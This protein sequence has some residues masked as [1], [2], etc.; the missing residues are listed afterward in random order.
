MISLRHYDEISQNAEDESLS[1]EYS[2]LGSMASGIGYEFVHDGKFRGAS[3]NYYTIKNRRGWNQY[4]GT[5]ANMNRTITAS[6]IAVGA[7][8]G[9]GVFAGATIID[10]YN[11]K[12]IN[13][14]QA[15]IEGGSV[16]FSTIAPA[17]MSIPWNIGYEGI[18]RQLYGRN[19]LGSRDFIRP[20][21]R[22]ALNIEG[23]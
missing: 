2:I 5:K 9:L 12:R 17:W 10:Q 20:R 21:I 7:N 15:F 1:V 4:T 18:G 6:K 23:E 8:L 11:M 3:G 19:I 14:N 16:G 22:R 13:Q